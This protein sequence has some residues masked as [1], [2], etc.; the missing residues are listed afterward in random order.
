MHI[1]KDFTDKYVCYSFRIASPTGNI[2]MAS[3]KEGEFIKNGSP[4]EERT[5]R[6]IDMIRGFIGEQRGFSIQ[7]N[8]TIKIPHELYRVMTAVFFSFPIDLHFHRALQP[9]TVTTSTN[10]H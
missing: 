9:L 6:I 1:S 10:S 2:R 5:E 4:N 7:N 8:V 3:I